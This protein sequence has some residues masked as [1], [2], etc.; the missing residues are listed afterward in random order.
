MSNFLPTKGEILLEVTT[1]TVL[2]V[3]ELELEKGILVLCQF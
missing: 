3:F 1:Q 2:G